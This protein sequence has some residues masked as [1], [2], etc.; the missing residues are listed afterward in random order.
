MLFYS[1]HT[2]PRQLR[3]TVALFYISGYQLSSVLCYAHQKSSLK[4]T[5]YFV[6]FGGHTMLAFIS[7]AF[8]L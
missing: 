5:S 8:N 6:D 3:Y 1:N 7:Q 4:V 2:N